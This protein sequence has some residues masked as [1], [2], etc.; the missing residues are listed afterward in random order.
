[1]LEKWKLSTD[2]KGFASGLLTLFRMD[3]FP[4]PKR[5]PHIIC[6][7]ETWHSYTLPKEDPNNI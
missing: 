6:N 4:T 2:N 3:F 7:G 1:M 5:L